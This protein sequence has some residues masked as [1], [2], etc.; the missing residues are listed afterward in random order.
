MQAPSHCIEL[1]KFIFRLSA[2]ETEG[3][4]KMEIVLTPEEKQ[5]VIEAAQ[6]MAT[7]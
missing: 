4:Y 7:S 2:S 6:N 5:M 1:F 3:D